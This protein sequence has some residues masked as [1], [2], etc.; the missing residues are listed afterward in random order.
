MFQRGGDLLTTP[1]INHLKNAFSKIPPIVFL[2]YDL[3][4]SGTGKFD[5]RD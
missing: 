1:I 4:R 2:K 5:G 3:V